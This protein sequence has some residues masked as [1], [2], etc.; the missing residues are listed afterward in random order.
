MVEELVSRYGDLAEFWFDGGVLIPQKGGPDVLPIFEKH[1]PHCIYYH[2]EQRIDKRWIGNEAG[3][4]GD[5]CWATVPDVASLYQR[6]DNEP[7]KAK[8]L[9]NGDPDGRLWCPGMCDIPIRG[10]KGRHEW[11]WRPNDDDSVYPLDDLMDIYYK[12]VGRNCNLV[13]GA[14]PDRDGL[15]PDAD[16][17]RYA[18]F[19]R[20]VHRRFSKPVA[21]AGGIGET[22][23]LTLPRPS[24]V[25]HVIL[26]E[27]ITHGELVREYVVEGLTRGDTWM[28]LSSG[29]SIGHKRI[30]RFDPTEVGAVR[31]RCTKAI[32]TPRIRQFATYMVG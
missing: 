10:V 8:V 5:P 27:D 17:T 11:F 4:A 24:R 28:K 16:M 19:G 12:S 3:T 25:D 29:Q 6:W 30:L 1:Q 23:E 14:T 32:G 13:I 15:I 20:E 18:E 31:L 26:M 22:I 21:H 9:Q 2:S 7:H